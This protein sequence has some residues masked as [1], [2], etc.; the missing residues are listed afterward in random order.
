MKLSLRHFG[1]L[2]PRGIEPLSNAWKAL[3]L[4]T[5]PRSLIN[6]NRICLGA[7]IDETGEFCHSASQHPNS[8]EEYHCVLCQLWTDSSLLYL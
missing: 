2:R 1:R 4:T 3:M 8:M 6:D 5:T 7:Y